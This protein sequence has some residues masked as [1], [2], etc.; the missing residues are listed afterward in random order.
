MSRALPVPSL[1]P[2]ASLGTNARRVLAVRVDELFSYAPI[3]PDAEATEA[4]HD[5]RIA[6]KRLRYTLE[7]F[8]SVYGDEGEQV[9]ERLKDLQEDLGALHDHDVR[10]AMI[11]EGLSALED[12]TDEDASAL[13][14][15]LEAL[16]GRERTARAA[17]RTAVVER[18]RGLERERVQERLTALS[19]PSSLV[20]GSGTPAV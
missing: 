1:D 12:R 13:R 17:Y 20:I 9:I 16:L 6:T 2:E 4:L 14:P 18:W 19:G 8:P 15:G 5:A 7:L 11:D 10:I 3:I